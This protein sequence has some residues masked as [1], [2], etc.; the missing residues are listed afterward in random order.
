MSYEDQ[1][2]DHIRAGDREDARREWIARNTTY[3]TECCGAD[4]D[5]EDA[6]EGECPTTHS[7]NSYPRFY[8]PECPECGTWSWLNEI[9]PDG[10]PDA[11]D[12]AS[13]DGPDD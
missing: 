11:D 6:S 10:P 9:V 1:M 5:I 8:V 4:V 2:D 3:E 12:Y 13:G 7:P